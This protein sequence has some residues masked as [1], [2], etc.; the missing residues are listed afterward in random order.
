MT[1]YNPIL[2]VDSYKTSHYLQYPEGTQYVSSYIESRGGQFKEAV[3]FGLQAFIKQYL[4]TPI[5][6]EHIDEA[7]ELCL[8][9]GLPFNRE[10]WEYILQEHRGYLPIEIQAV[11]E[12]SVI[13]TKNVLAQVVN[14][15]PLCFWL[16]SYIETA[17]LRAVWYP[18]TVATQSREAKKVIQRYLL[19]TA[20]NLESLPFKLHDF[21]ARG[22]SSEETAAIGGLAHLVNFQ[23]TDTIAAVL[24]GR[25][26]YAAPMAG[27]SIPAAEHSTMTSWGREQE[28]NAYE[29]MLA[30]FGG[31]NRLVAVVSDSYDLWSAIEDIWGG[32]LK[33]KVENNGGTLVIRPDSGDPV[34]IVTQT[35]ER[36]MRIFGASINSK[37]YR[38]LPDFIRVIQ[39]DGIS[40]HTIEAILSAMKVRKQSAENI[41]FGMGGELLQKV[42]RDTMKFA[43]KASA[44]RV[45]GLWR[46]VYKDPA[47]DSGKRSKK[48]RLALVYRQDGTP[49][50]IREQD[51][52]DRTNLLETVYRNGQLLIKQNLE[53]I[54]ARAVIV[55][56]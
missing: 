38:V 54:R 27:F 47:T 46:D 2:N 52:G 43:M 1:H 40:L 13:P 49:Y 36:L 34:D 30:Q 23:G 19:E 39:G 8:A 4:T 50:T 41:S 25:R 48:G 17:L 42:N 45:N 53:A 10:G 6:A 24:A 15:D 26:Y 9:H 11:A 3:F 44:V 28:A 22:A 37:G 35:I 21:G 14:T 33:D 5:T 29:N 32:E 51:I 31:D 7:E 56:E 18:T 20:E 12:G 16:T 55:E